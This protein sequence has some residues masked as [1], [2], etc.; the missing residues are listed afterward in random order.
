MKLS[1]PR[2]PNLLRSDGDSKLSLQL[3]Q[4][5]QHYHQYQECLCFPRSSLL[6]LHRHCGLLP[7]QVSHC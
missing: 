5:P 7:Y 1:P 3:P 6:L 2:Y 4:L